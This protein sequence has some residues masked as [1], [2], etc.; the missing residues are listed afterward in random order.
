MHVIDRK[1]LRD[2]WVDFPDAEGPLKAW[3]N[4]A[5]D[6]HWQNPAEMKEKYG[7]AS[8]AG[9]CTVFNIHGNDYRLVVWINYVTQRV[10]VR[11]VGT[12][13][14]YDKLDIGAM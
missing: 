1:K 7:N 14:D 12:L 5:T 6:A 2:F 9:N 10:F 3:F 4:E 8:I 13:K 11:W